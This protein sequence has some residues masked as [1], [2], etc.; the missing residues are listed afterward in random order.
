[1]PAA[2][3]L[4]QEKANGFSNKAMRRALHALGGQ[5]KKNGYQGEWQWWL[6]ATGES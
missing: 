5:S 2:D 4:A 3:V 6:S 1:M